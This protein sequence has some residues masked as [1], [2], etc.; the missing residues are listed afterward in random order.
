MFVFQWSTWI[1][2]P[3]F[4]VIIVSLGHYAF[5]NSCGQVFC[6]NS[7]CLIWSMWKWIVPLFLL[8][9]KHSRMCPG[10]CV[11]TDACLV[12]AVLVVIDSF[13]CHKQRQPHSLTSFPYSRGQS[14]YPPHLLTLE[15]VLAYWPN[16]KIHISHLE[17]NLSQSLCSRYLY[18]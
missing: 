16:I 18:H 17:V 6:L 8:V 9:K 1:F 4:Q 2:L 7:A 5:H 13:L 15:C 14:S 10:P 11:L 12:N 3:L